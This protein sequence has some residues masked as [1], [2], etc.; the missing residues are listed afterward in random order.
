VI[1][2]R[3]KKYLNL[4]REAQ[5]YINQYQII[6]KRIIKEAKRRENN[7]HVFRAKN[8]TK[9]MWHTINTE[10]GKSLQSDQKI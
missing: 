5:D 3:T 9:A 10:V 7:R 6:Y 2:K 1:F 4:S 8:R